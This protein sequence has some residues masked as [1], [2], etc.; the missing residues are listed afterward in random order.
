MGMP[1]TTSVS[2]DTKF[3]FATLRDTQAPWSKEVNPF[4]SQLF[5]TT[6]NLVISH[7]SS[8]N[9]PAGSTEAWVPPWFISQP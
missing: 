8:L 6:E 9:K 3:P 4:L 2:T 5:H 1:S 7:S